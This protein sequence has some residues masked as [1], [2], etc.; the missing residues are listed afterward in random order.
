MKHIAQCFYC[1]S[2][3]DLVI[4]VAMKAQVDRDIKIC[5]RCLDLPLVA[6]LALMQICLTMTIAQRQ[7]LASAFRHNAH[8]FV[9]NFVDGLTREDTNRL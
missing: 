2:I 9:L 5:K 8:Y 3:E 6:R 7:I 4:D 1:H